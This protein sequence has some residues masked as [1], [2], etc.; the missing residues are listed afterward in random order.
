MPCYDHRGDKDMSVAEERINNLKLDMKKIRSKRNDLA[1]LL[2]ES[3]QL[4][5]DSDLKNQMSQ[6][7]SDWWWEHD[8]A[9]RKRKN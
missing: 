5:V 2:C 8:K 1:R 3:C 4:L 6:E 9:D 7:L